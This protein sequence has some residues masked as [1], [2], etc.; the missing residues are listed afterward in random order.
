MGRTLRAELRKLVH[1]VA[2]IIVVVC[3][4]YILTDARTTYSYARL[5]TPLAVSASARIAGEAEGCLDIRGGPISEEC[6]RK[7]EN[8]G[9]NDKFAINGVRLGR[10]T[11]SLSSWPGMLRFVSHELATG[12][13]WVLVAVLLALHV[14]GE[15]SSRTAATTIIA[16]GSYRRF[17]LA[18]VGSIWLAMIGI[19]LAGTTILWL[20]NST[21]LGKVGVPDPIL[22]PGDP[23]TWHQTALQ[24]DATWSSWTVSASFL[25]ITAVSW[26]LFIIVGVGVAALIRRTL[27]TVAVWMG[28]L[29]AMLVLARFLGRTDY[30]P[31]GVMGQVLHLSETPFGVRDTRLWLVPGAPGFIQ[32]TARVVSVETGQLLTWV[33]IPLALA[34]AAAFAFQRRRVIG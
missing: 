11:N 31:I 24:P 9:L 33:A 32:D 27:S 30:T 28:A 5:Q 2:A 20:A 17:W 15:W 1:P 34:F 4:A 18:K 16:T 6:Q 14:A 19:T 21:F 13:G 3:F 25:G 12:L 8:A 10:V 22:Q 7:L 29:S 26:L 23:S